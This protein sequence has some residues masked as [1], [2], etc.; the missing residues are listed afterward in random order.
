MK[1]RDQTQTRELKDLQVRLEGQRTESNQFR[2][3]MEKE[4]YEARLQVQATPAYSLVK[5]I[6]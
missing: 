6:I 4:L 3:R 2:E 1:Q 5:E